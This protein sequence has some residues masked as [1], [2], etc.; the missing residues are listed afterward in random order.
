MS[1]RPLYLVGV[2]FGIGFFI[3]FFNLHNGLFWDDEDWILNNATVHALNWTNIKFWFT[4]NTLAGIGL[5]SNYYRP[6]L[7]FT[8][9][10][11][12]VLSGVKPFGYH[13]VNNLLHIANA[14]LL[15]VVLKKLFKKESFAFL[16]ALIFLIH[17][18][19]T[20]AITYIAGRG[21]ILVTLFMLLGVW[22]FIKSLPAQAGQVNNLQA[23]PAGWG[24]LIILSL[25]LA[26]LSRE[27]AIVF[28]VLL[29]VI[30][31]SFLSQDRFLKSIK[32]G[33]IKTW[34]YFAVVAVYGILRL[35]TL[36]FLDTLNFYVVPN[37]YSQHFS[38]RFFT[39]LSTLLTYLKLLVVPIGLHMERGTDV[40]DSLF[41]WP[42]WLGAILVSC[43][44]YFVYRF[45][46]KYKTPNTKYQIPNTDFGVWLFGVGWFAAT[47]APVSGITPI[48]ALIYEHWLYLP[49][50][51]FWSIICFYLVKLYDYLTSNGRVVGRLLLAISLLV[52]FSF[53]SYQA[54]KRNIL[55]GNP[56]AFYL[57]ILK[58]EPDSGRINNNVGNLYFNR[59]DKTMAEI[60]YKKAVETADTFP[61]SHLN[62]GSVL[63]SK[64]DYFGAAQEYKKAI[65]IDP[66]FYYA[67][68]NLVILYAK[69]GNIKEAIVYVEQLKKLLPENPRVYYNTALLYLADR[70]NKK[71]IEN[72]NEGL[73]YIKL[74]PESGP[75]FEDL[76]KTLNKPVRV[77]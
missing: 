49:M 74:D 9:A 29:L 11:N 68:Q 4:N 22:L 7:F 24:L 64:N 20:E 69:T 31:I 75:L 30:Y 14:I 52:Y 71:A 48:N 55:W 47:I 63:E 45:Y 39:F 77:K 28:P 23:R 1:K 17:P 8:F 66:N 56:E 72:A 19:Q 76:V 32:N 15:F 43:I 3:Y 58:Y 18:L 59:G 34:P 46:Q 41:R 67:H 6:F 33:L 35:T 60:Y 65:E 44:V 73:K 5:K 70:N 25:V 62:Y 57:D 51:G 38:V 50:I 26:L 12:Y 40:F 2:L 61:Q 37:V 53:F 36:N 21:D 42:V 10:I 13:L 27:T 54:I 16:V